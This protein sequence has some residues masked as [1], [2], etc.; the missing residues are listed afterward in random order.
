MSKDLV[1][2]NTKRFPGHTYREFK[3][4]CAKK[5]LP[6]KDGLV[7]AMDDFVAKFVKEAKDE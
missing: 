4:C 6:V 2:V 1:D 3:A 7:I 5:G